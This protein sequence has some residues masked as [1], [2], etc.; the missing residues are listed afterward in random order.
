M[1][2]VA[3]L[4]RFAYDG[5]LP[6]VLCGNLD[7][8]TEHCCFMAAL[9]YIFATVYG[10]LRRKS[11]RLGMVSVSRRRELTLVAAVAIFGR[12]VSSPSPPLLVSSGSSKTPPWCIIDTV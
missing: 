4:T 6:T 12:T 11:P 1:C 3:L 2:E 9:T 8:K 7:Y 5:E 10:Y